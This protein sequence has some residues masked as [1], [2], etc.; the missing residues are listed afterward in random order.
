M[1]VGGIRWAVMLQ[2]ENTPII[3]SHP[4]CGTVSEDKSCLAEMKAGH[5]VYRQHEKWRTFFEWGLEPSFRNSCH[6]I[7]PR[8]CAAPP[9]GWSVCG[10][11]EPAART[12]CTY[13]VMPVICR[14][15]KWNCSTGFGSTTDKPLVRFQRFSLQFSKKFHKTHFC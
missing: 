11:L 6:I 9:T 5:H 14:W 3:F 15:L 13:K 10:A 1:A 2:Q 7:S 8:C 4:T 12:T